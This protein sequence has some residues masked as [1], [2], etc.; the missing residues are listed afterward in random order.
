MYENDPKMQ[1]AI[2]G[3]LIVFLLFI[4]SAAWQALFGY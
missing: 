1:D 2:A 3:F 4:L